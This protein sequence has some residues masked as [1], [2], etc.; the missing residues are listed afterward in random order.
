MSEERNWPVS[1][2]VVMLQTV[3]TGKAQE[4]Y[5]ALTMEDRKDYNKVKG[6]I[7]KAY[8]LVPEAYRQRFRGWSVFGDHQTH[9]ELGYWQVPLTPR[10]RE[11]TSF[12]TPSGL[13]S[14]SVM[15]FGLR[16]APATFQR[17]M[18]HVVFGLE[19]CAVY[20]DDV[21]VFSETWEQHL[22]RLRALLT[23]LVEACLTVNLAKCEFAKATVRYLGKEVGQGKVRPVLA[24]VLAIQ[25]FPPP[26][27]KKELMRFLGMVAA[28]KLD[29]PFKLQVDASQLVLGSFVTD[30]GRR[31][32]LSHKLLLPIQIADGKVGGLEGIEQIMWCW[33]QQFRV[34]SVLRVIS[35]EFGSVLR[36]ISVEFGSV[37]RVISVEFGSVLRVISV[38]FGSVLRVISVEFGSVLRVGSLSSVQ[39]SE[40]FRLSSV[41]FSESVRLSSIQFSESFRLS[42]VQ[43]SESVRLSS[44]QFSESF[45]LSSVQF[46]ESVR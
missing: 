30:G 28:P 3:I 2:R 26:S 37:L 31:T 35:V 8:E 40:S 7:L 32:R 39:F 38:E 1:I 42:S 6:A 12:I 10:A 34:T 24:K 41:Q 14:Y 36:V 19:G 20:L 15:S 29:M 5:A 45:R 22:I 44:V 4:A 25:Q 16:N 27:T 23:R 13:Y 46:S 33:G 18:N 43:F 9:S 21:I 17:L 11:V